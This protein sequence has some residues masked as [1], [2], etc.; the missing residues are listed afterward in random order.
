MPKIYLYKINLQGEIEKKEIEKLIKEINDK[1]TDSGWFS[2][3]ENTYEKGEI[4]IQYFYYLTEEEVKEEIREKLWDMGDEIANSLKSIPKILGRTFCFINTR[5]KTLEIYDGRR[6]E[7]IISFLKKFGD[8]EEFR[9]PKLNVQP[10]S[11][12]NDEFWFANVEDNVIFI[13]SHKDF[14]W[15]PRYEIRQVIKELV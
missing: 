12:L 15:K 13:P 6:K 1:K 10:K 5:L 4:V 3:R 7:E 8:I 9:L 2:A 11:Y 14:L